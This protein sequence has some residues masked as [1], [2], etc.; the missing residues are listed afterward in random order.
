MEAADAGRLPLRIFDDRDGIPHNSVYSLTFDKRGYLWCATQDGAA[1]YNG[2]RWRAIPMPNRAV[3]NY[4]RAILPASDGALWFG[5]QDG[6][7]A[8]LKDGA[9]QWFDV[10][11]QFP[12]ERVNAILESSLPDGVRR[13]WF[14]TYGKGA[15]VL[16]GG[17]FSTLDSGDGLPE[18]RV[19]SFAEA[20]SPSGVK[21]VWATTEAGVAYFEKG[22][23]HLFDA[24]GQLPRVSFGNL[25]ETKS[26]TK[27]PTLWLGSWG[28]GLFQV[29]GNSVRKFD[30]ASGFPSNLISSLAE[31]QEADGSRSLWVGTNGG[32]LVRVSPGGKWTSFGLRAGLP[33]NSIFALLAPQGGP[34]TGTLWM[35]TGGGGVAC[36]RM[37]RWVS[38]DV[39]VGLPSHQVYAILETRSSTNNPVFWFGTNGGLARLE[40]GSFKVFN[41]ETGLPGNQISTLSE[42]PGEKGN[43]VVA[44]FPGEGL[45]IE[46]DG[47]FVPWTEGG[48]PPSSR[49]NRLVTG[50]RKGKPVL[51]VATDDRGLAEFSE[52]RWTVHDVSSGLPH[53]SVLSLY[54]FPEAD[55]TVSVWAGTRG[56]LARLRAGGMTV[57]RH[58]DGLP[59]NEVR[60]LYAV[61]DPPNRPKLW[62]GTAT[63]LAQI[64]PEAESSEVHVIS[65]IG[66]AVLPSQRVHIILQDALHR[67]FVATTRGVVCLTPVRS[68]K[69][70]ER[71][72]APALYTTDD[73]LPSNAATYGSGIVDSKG[74]V[75]IGTVQGAAVFDPA[76]EWPDA[77]RKP[78]YIERVLAGD[79]VTAAAKLQDL[80]YLAN[81]LTFEFALVSMFR[82]KETRY[83][84]QLDGFEPVSRDWSAEPVRRYTNVPP[85][86]YTFRVWGRDAFGNTSGPA[87]LKIRI[88]P[89]PWRSWWAF[90]VYAFLAGGTVAIFVRFRVASLEQQKSRLEAK[91]AQRTREL[92]VSEY[93][94]QQASRA[95]SQFLANMS[96]E[97][98]TPLTAVIGY[99]EMLVEDA[100]DRGDDVLK[101]DLERIR[102]SARHL[103]GMIND[104]LDLSKIEA[105]KTDLELSDFAINPMLDE[106]AEIVRALSQSNQNVVALVAEN[107]G[108][109][110]SDEIKV[111]QCLLNL[112]SNAAKFTRAGTITVEARA[113]R[114]REDDGVLFLVSDT[115]VGMTPEERKRIFQPFVQADETTSRTFGGTGLGLTITRHYCQLLGGS[116]DVLSAKGK[117][118]T[119]A[120]WLPR[121]AERHIPR[122]PV[123]TWPTSGEE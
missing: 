41:V 54:L 38:F 22:R 25:L 94:A 35:G 86:S 109:M 113:E 7:I 43:R 118:S 50:L 119:F 99:A 49:I 120:I 65:G 40:N 5:R 53:N 81:N 104:V 98:R 71:E 63:G 87:E 95:K 107:L 102:L 123:E 80:S 96:H 69:G 18:N 37:G 72:F 91:V 92:R 56:G 1:F 46:K 44:G 29:N 3:S 6:G 10:P 15:V 59:N 64:D 106:V 32:G 78:L 55:G 51:W 11:S 79:A 36:L 76:R 4:V 74:R 90:L 108:L 52:G 112:G 67:T 122:V 70:R 45:V 84:S 27:E 60:T 117:G 13:I 9:W 19:W 114:R 100:R 66:N 17:V 83:R 82:E 68:E 34:A 75:W 89:A 101:E 105:G 2:V 47:T 62:I 111:R 77:V 116:I 21:T 97:L 24:S 57:F 88:R 14:A 31:T 8:R 73:G 23:F 93:R 85:G 61:S 115:G 39:T 121:N 103:L 42:W 26:G 110:K 58:E 30:V 28:R 48:P 33:S 12:H 20:T 16:E